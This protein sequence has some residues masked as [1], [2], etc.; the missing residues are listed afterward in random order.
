MNGCTLYFA[1]TVLCLSGAGLSA[2]ADSLTRRVEAA[3]TQYDRGDREGANREFQTFIDIYNAR[4]DRLTSAE[5][6]AVARAVTYLGVDD[7]QLFK[8]ALKAYDRAIAAD[9]ANLDARVRLGE[10]FIAKYNGTEAKRTLVEALRGNPM[11]V[12][13]L[14][15]DARRRDFDGEGGA[16][17]LLLKALEVEPENVRARV[18]RAQF[19]AD[20][21]DFMGA[22]READRALRA[23]GDDGEALAFRAAL[24]RVANDSVGYAELRRRYAALYPK[25]AGIQVATS[26][27]LSRVRQYGLAAT[28]AREGT[29]VDAKNWRAHAMLGSNLLRLGDVPAARASLDTAFKGD[30]YDLWTKNTLDLLDTFGQYDHAST[31]KFRFMIETTESGVLSLYLTEI[32]DKAYSTFQKRYAFTPSGPVRVEV[33]R[34]HADFSVR[35]VGLAGIGALGVSFGNVIAFDSPAA[36]DAGPFNWAST[37][38]HELAHTFTLGASDMRVPRWLSEG[39]SVYEERRGRPGWGQNVSPAFLKAF[40]EKKLVPAS[41]LNDGFVRPAYPQQVI[42]SYY[43]ASLLCEMIT[44]DLGEQAL[45]L[46]L[47]AY[48]TGQ[49]TEQV[50]QRVLKMDPATLDRRFEMYMRERFGKAMAAVSDR[51]VNVEQYM[52]PDQLIARADARPDNYWLQVTVG[53]ALIQRREQVRAIPILERARALFPDYGGADGAYPALMRARQA[54]GDIRSAAVALGIAASLGD[55]PYEM[56]LTLTDL[57][58][59]AGD[60][61][62]AAGA[63]E[64]A[65]FMNPFEI[66]QHERLAHLMTVVGDMPRAVRE[67]AAVV[68]LNPVDRAEALFRLAIAQRDAGDAANAKRSVLRALEVAPHFERAQHLLLAIVEKKP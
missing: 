61:V 59:E 40:E 1:L 55:M 35:T 3:V 66:V 7:P 37:A 60:T 63:L 33:Y 57:W 45:S 18:L 28:V 16:D 49:S 6:V 32:L 14:V 56:H 13:A 17:T 22:A 64:S 5:F 48:R 47:A 52:A 53:R 21:E 2:Q 38:W 41:R 23:N 43:Q 10:L 44:R 34:S 27:L 12:P 25:E 4:A 15:A 8:D 9:P 39:L 67:R 62:K 65:M 19:L 46:M 26:T 50:F 24:Y 11:H 30:P 54:N 42:F 58:L 36:K 29:Q 20:V 31:D 68:A 51:E